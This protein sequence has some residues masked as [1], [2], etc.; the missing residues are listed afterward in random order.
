MAR[1]KSTQRAPTMR[2]RTYDAGGKKRTLQRV[3]DILRANML[4]HPGL[5]TKLGKKPGKES[6]VATY[7]VCIDP[8]K[9]L[10]R[11][12]GEEDVHAFIASLDRS[13]TLYGLISEQKNA[14]KKNAEFM[15]LVKELTL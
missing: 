10:G 14:L 11:E 8:V 9:M 1:A 13:K 12:H 2:K 3:R 4:N 7:L 15:A 5:F 6:T